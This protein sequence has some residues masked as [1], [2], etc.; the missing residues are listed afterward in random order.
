M[1]PAGSRDGYRIGPG[2]LLR[3]TVYG[4]EDLN[5]IVVVE[6]DGTFSFPLIGYVTVA[7]QTPAELEAHLRSRL[8]RGLIRD[9]QV[10]V[11]VQEYKSKVVYVV[12]EIARPGPYPLTGQMSLVEILARAGPVSAHAG[13]EVVVVRGGGRAGRA[14]LPSEVAAGG[15]GDPARVASTLPSG[16]AP[17]GPPVEVLHVDVG[18]IQAGRIERNILLQP[19]D[20]V[21]VPQAARIFVSG[22]VRNPGAF[23]YSRGLTVR[24]AIALAGGFTEDASTGSA[25]MVRAI[26]GEPKT[27]KVKL[28]D[29]V[30]PG[31]T[32]VVKAKLF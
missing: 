29:P 22:E 30:D 10:T 19:D 25:R 9:P 20:T 31:D 26:Q 17:P 21:F 18:D 11:V 15:V 27:F 6:P 32:V 4:H 8:A 7:E 3:I 1:P 24:Q 16:G 12:G 14:V 2:D 23:A 5:Q 28:D 13:T